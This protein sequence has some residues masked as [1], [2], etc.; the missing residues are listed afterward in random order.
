MN[1]LDQTK[2]P[3]T[4]KTKQTRRGNNLLIFIAFTAILFA[5]YYKPSIDSVYCD[6][7]ILASQ[8]EVIMLGTLWCPYC[9]KARK[10]FVKNNIH[11]CEY[12]VEDNAE[13]EQKYA[14]INKNPGM[15]IGI[16]VLLIG[17]YMLSGFDQKSI[18]KALS[19]NRSNTNKL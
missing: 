7:K 19:K 4:K 2:K 8:P 15:P 1:E 11:Y 18:E 12:N 5:I 17:D 3:E 6:K 16:P 14:S 9:Y 13:G 10:Y